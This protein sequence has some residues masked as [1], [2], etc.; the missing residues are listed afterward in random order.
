MKRFFIFSLSMFVSY[1]LLAQE[2][3]PTASSGRD[4]RPK[5]AIGGTIRD[6]RHVPQQNIKVFVYK[7][8]SEIVASGY[9]DEN[10]KFETSSYG[11]GEYTVKVI[12]PSFRRVIISRVP[13]V[14]HKITPLNLLLTEPG[15]D[16]TFVYSDVAPKRRR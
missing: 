9:T 8:E 15:E 16:S 1:S 5:T 2:S 7:G 10:G 6:L 4:K 11:T 14:R 12:Y 13:L 3:A